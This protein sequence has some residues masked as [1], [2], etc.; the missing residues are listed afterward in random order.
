MFDIDQKPGTVTGLIPVAAATLIESGSLFG[1]DVTGFAVPAASATCTIVLGR[2]A[3]EADNSAGVA[4]DIEVY[5]DRGVFILTSE[6][7]DAVTMAGAACYASGNDSVKTTNT[8]AKAGICI[9]FTPDG[10]LVVDTT[11]AP[12][13]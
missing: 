11:V 8:L 3:V 2:A 12:L 5:G 7:P 9:G 4:G 10:D 6:A 13:I 1:T